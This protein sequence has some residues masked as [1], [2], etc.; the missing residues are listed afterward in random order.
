MK[1]LRRFMNRMTASV[2]GRRDDSRVREELAEHLAML[3]DTYVREGLSPDEARRRARMTLGSFDAATEAYRDEQRLRTVEAAWEDVRYAARTLRTRPGFAL[4]VVLTLALG[5]GANVAVFTIINAVLLRPLPFPRSDQLV[6]VYTR[7]LPSWG[8]D[9]PYAPVSRPELAEIRSHVAAFTDLAAYSLP[10]DRTLTRASGETERVG[11]MLVT[12]NFFDVLGVRPARGRA[13]SQQEAQQRGTCV[14][15][16]REAGQGSPPIDVGST[17]RLDDAPCDVVGVVPRDFVFRDE[18]VKVWTALDAE[19]AAASRGRHYMTILARLREGVTVQHVDAQLESLRR[20]WSETNPAHYAKG[21]FAVSRPLHEDIVGDQR[22]RWLLLGGGVALVLL[23]VCV[24]IAAL[25]VSS[26]EARRREFAVRHALGANRRRLVRQLVTETLFLALIGGVI[27]LAF[28]KGLLAGLLALYPQRLPAS[29]AIAIDHVT[30]LYM[31]ALVVVTG[32]VVGLVPALQATGAHMHE[33]LRTDSRTATSSRRAVVARSL[34]VISQLAV[35]VILLVGALLLIRSYHQLQQVDLGLQPDGVLTFGLVIPGARQ[36]D[37]AARRT[38]G[39]IE[40]RLSITPGVE[41]VGGMSS[42]PLADAGPG[43]LAFQM[44]DRPEPPP[45]ETP[46]NARFVTVTPQVFQAL[47]V[48]VKRGRHLAESDLD[49]RPFVVVINEAFAR[50]FWPGEDAVGKTIR[51]NPRDKTSPS[52]QIVGIVGDIRSLG[53]GEPAPPTAYVPLHQTNLPPG[54]ARVQAFV[55]R[56]TGNPRDL[57]ASARAAVA[58]VDSGLPLLD[59]QPMTDVVARASGQPRFTTLVMSFFAG[60]A[61]GLAALG[62]YGTL[63]FSVERRVREIGVRLA[64]GS[65]TGE[66]FRLIVGRSMG[67]ALLG[68]LVGIPAALALTPLMRSVLSDVATSDPWTYVAVVAMLGVA[69]F[70]ASYLPA[71]RATRVDPLVAL[72]TD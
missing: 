69:A 49:G 60:A 2:L 45:G 22:D 33:V 41:N 38:L 16:V 26:G 52:R 15:L 6:S 9:M 36:E 42:L 12:P 30:V 56:T 3:T 7:F 27:G 17:I 23:I 31:F 48:P 40:D 13:F 8:F 58:A 51:L 19:E 10:F 1:A 21:H 11:T 4:A 5:L 34:L 72:R 68:V 71:R 59:L 35:S 67:L 66:I 32:L 25:L 46:W 43:V 14:A 70:L 54:A 63:A 28:A 64:L 62:L 50:R 44:E 47:R 20:F 61:F 18:R 55:V 53:P 39:A 37:A 57:A 65:S 24:N 29:Q